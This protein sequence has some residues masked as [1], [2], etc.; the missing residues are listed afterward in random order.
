VNRTINN[1]FAY[2]FTIRDENK[3]LHDP[4]ILQVS[5]K[6]GDATEDVLTLGG[7]A[8]RDSQLTKISTGVYRVDY[9]LDVLGEWRINERWTDDGWIHPIKNTDM[10][11]TVNADPHAWVDTP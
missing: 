3:A 10:V 2:K 4:A 7:V 6:K 9:K 8:P 5:F 11:I 1:T